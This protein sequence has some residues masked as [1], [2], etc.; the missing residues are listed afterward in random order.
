[1]CVS[2]RWCL[3]LSCAAFLACGRGGARR[4]HQPA[5]VATPLLLAPLPSRTQGHRPFSPLPPRACACLVPA[6][7]GL[8]PWAGV[9]SKSSCAGGGH[10]QPK[11]CRSFAIRLD[12]CETD[13][14]LSLS[15]LFLFVSSCTLCKSTT[16]SNSSILTGGSSSTQARGRS[17]S[18]AFLCPRSLPTLPS[19]R[20]RPRPAHEF[21]AL[22]HPLPPS[23]HPPPTHTTQHTAPP[24]SRTRLRTQQFFHHASSLP[25]RSHHGRSPRHRPPCLLLHL[26][27]GRVQDPEHAWLGCDRRGQ[28]QGHQHLQ[29]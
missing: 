9:T 13:L 14:H 26:R 23:S 12:K 22:T 4:P 28:A 10:P 18:V 27:P 11:S 29:G 24:A 8:W 7:C 3:M 19:T 17:L 16:A 21:T 6:H 20:T 5:F 1:M 25:L 15:F 2:L